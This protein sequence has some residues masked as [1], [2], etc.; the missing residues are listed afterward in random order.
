MLQ[1]CERLFCKSGLLLSK[2]GFPMPGPVMS[3]LDVE[4]SRWCNDA[5]I[6]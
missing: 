4:R 3:E 2:F 6:E 1:D 5:E